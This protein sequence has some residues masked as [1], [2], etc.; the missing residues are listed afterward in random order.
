MQENKYYLAIVS[1]TL[2]GHLIQKYNILVL[3]TIDFQGVKVVGRIII[4]PLHICN[5][6]SNNRHKFTS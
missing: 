5:A 1:L 6:V 2:K 3:T 4:L